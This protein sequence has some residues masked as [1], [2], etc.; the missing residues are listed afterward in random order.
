MIS[1]PKAGELD[2]VLGLAAR[3]WRLFPCAP[4]T[5]T[6]LLK[7][8]PVLAS[9]DPA[10]IRKWAVKH[11]GCNWGL[12]TGPDSGVFVLDVDGERGRA[13]LATLEVQHGPLPA[14][15]VSHTGREDGGEH[16]WFT[17]PVDRNLRNCTGKLGDGLDIR[18]AGGYVIVPPSIHPTGRAYQW[19]DPNLSIADA[20]RWLLEMV[21]TPQRFAPAPAVEIGIL[22]DGQRNDGLTRLGGALRR[23]GAS[24]QELEAELLRANTRRCH[25]S[26]P[27][28]EV[29]KIAA[30]VGRY[31]VG[32]PDPLETAWQATQEE[33][34]P[35]R[36]ER[37]L[38]LARQLQL[39]RPGQA[40]ALP[41]L[42]IAALMEI[43]WTTVSLYRQ[44]AVT[45]GLLEPVSEYIPHRRAG[46]YRCS[47]GKLSLRL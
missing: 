46:L 47:L 20:P 2:R 37:F 42:R 40:I 14:A 38:A 29:L 21:T 30:S 43:H 5:K 33:N 31:P 41:L 8:W 4:H 1:A 10:T 3:R 18:A 34:Y 27:D 19:A 35:S 16:R 45:D 44:K 7:G 26:L 32:G 12:A 24:L 22:R 39:A 6:P 15:L 28:A 36:Y 11:P 23:R 17:W 9:S 13:S 25:P